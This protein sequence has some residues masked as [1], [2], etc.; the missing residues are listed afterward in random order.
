MCFGR[1]QCFSFQAWKVWGNGVLVQSLGKFWSCMIMINTCFQENLENDLE[2]KRWM[3]EWF[4]CS[5]K[6]HLL[7]YSK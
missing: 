2:A 6:L 4:S 1:L 7:L 3:M 5:I